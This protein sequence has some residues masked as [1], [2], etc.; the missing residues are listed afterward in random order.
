MNQENAHIF[1]HCAIRKNN[2]TK[3]WGNSSRR[4]IAEVQILVG[5]FQCLRS[6]ALTE[7]Q[8]VHVKF[9]EGMRKLQHTMKINLDISFSMSFIYVQLMAEDTQDI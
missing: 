5:N 1:R 2:H 6:V 3:R 9:S 8:Y 7:Y 4:L